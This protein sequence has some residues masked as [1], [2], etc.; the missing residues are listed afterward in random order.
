MHEVPQKSAQRLIVQ[1]ELLVDML[2]HY[3]CATSKRMS[4]RD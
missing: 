4:N 1:V 2:I 3:M